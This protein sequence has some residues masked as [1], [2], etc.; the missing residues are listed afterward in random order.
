MNYRIPFMRP[1][2]S[3]FG[4]PQPAS[5]ALAADPQCSSD[6]AQFPPAAYRIRA[7]PASWLHLLM[8]QL[9][10]SY[11]RHLIETDFDSAAP[12]HA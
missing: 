6:G 4:D 7:L 11:M 8:N 3:A 2:R 1:D 12:A 5:K 10:L 9:A